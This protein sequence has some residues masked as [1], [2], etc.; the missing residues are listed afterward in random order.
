MTPEERRIFTQ[1]VW[2]LGPVVLAVLLAAVA[3]WKG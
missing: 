3:A 1:A 2:S